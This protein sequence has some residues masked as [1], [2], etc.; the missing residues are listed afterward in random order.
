MKFDTVRIEGSIFTEDILDKIA[1]GDL[2]GQ[3]PADFNIGHGVK[4]KDEIAAAWADARAQWEI[5]KRRIERLEEKDSGEKETRKFWAFPFL[6]LLGYDVQHR[7]APEIVNQREYDIPF[8]AANIDD[9]PVMIKGFRQSLDRKEDTRGDGGDTRVKMSPHGLVQ[10][11]LNLTE[12]LYALVTN[13]MALRVLRDSSRLVK[14]SFLEFDLAAMMEEEHYADFAL[15]YRLLHVTRMPARMDR[16]PESL[17]EAYHQDSLESGA[18]IREGLSEAV[19]NAIVSMGNGFLQHPDNQHLRSAVE[20]EEVKA[21]DYYLWLLRLIYRM[22]FLM[23]IE[24]RRL[25]YPKDSDSKKQDIYYNYYS[26]SHMRK[27]CESVHALQDRHHDLWIGLCHTFS[28]FESRSAGKHL[29]IQP[30]SGDLFGVDATGLLN[31]CCLENRTLLA[32]VRSLSLFKNRITGQMMKVNYGSLNVE[33]FGSVYEG[34]LEYRPVISKSNGKLAFKFWKSEER[35]TSGSHYTPDE[36]V[37]PLI[38][39][40]L[41]HVIEEKLE[42]AAQVSSALELKQA[43]ERALLSIRVCDVA[44]G[45][46]HILLNAARRIGTEL[47][48]VRT[49]E[50][51]P[52]QV[53]LREGIRDVV[54]HCIYGVD[55]NPLA[56]EL[57]KVA[58]WLEAHQPGQPLNFLDHRIKCGDAIVGLANK[59]ELQS[60]I[61]D[62]AF[63]TLEGDDKGIAAAARKKNKIEREGAQK[64]LDFKELVHDPMS[65]ITRMFEALERMPER[66]VEEIQN[67]KEAYK[68]LINRGLWVKMKSLADMKV[69]Q[70]FIPKTVD[71]VDSL[72]THGQ[73]RQYLSGMALHEV[74]PHHPRFSEAAKHRFFHWFLEFPDVFA[75]G[76]FDCILGNPPF[77]GNRKIKSHLGADYLK[78]V[79]S[80]YAPAGAIELVGYFFRRI[81]NLLKP[82]GFQALIATNTISQGA[83]RQGGLEVIEKDGGTINFAIR[84]MKWPGLAAVEVSL[85]SIF[86]GKWT[87]SFI[88]DNKK[89]KIISTYLDDTENL[90]NPFKLNQN[91]DKSFQ[92]SIVLGKG[93]VLKPHEAVE[94]IEK[95]SKNKNVIFPYLNGDDLNSRPDQS[96]S[97]WVIN[98]FNWTEDKA[99][100]EYLDCYE[101]IKKLVKPER[102][103]KNEKGEYVLRKPLPQRWWQYGDKRPKLYESIN[104]LARVLAISEVSKYCKFIFV[105]KDIVYMHTLKLISIDSFATQYILNSSI[106]EYWAWKYSSTMGGVGLRY[107]PSSAFETFPFPQGL[108]AEMEAGL[109]RLGEEYHE[110]RRKLMLKMKLGL[111][112]TYN[113]FHNPRLQ[114]I[115]NEELS[116]KEIEKKDGKESA[117]LWRHL[118]KTEETC[119]FN[120]AVTDILHLRKLHK[121]MDETVLKA[122]GWTDIQLAHDFY[123]V[124]YLPEN[125]RTRYTIS[126]DARKDILQRLLL[127]N[128]KLHRQETEAGLTL[129]AEKKTKES[130]AEEDEEFTLKP[131]PTQGTLF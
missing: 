47:A 106:N 113:Q 22:L 80:Y 11:Y 107:T 10:E 81:F 93:F 13:G 38:K 101:I 31:Q 79:T 91:V 8:R 37:Q 25:I 84:S 86:R 35:S 45:S 116:A 129:K 120:E 124:D 63:K 83:A 64:V 115:D 56:V 53:P 19:E 118:K 5:F 62:E 46:G 55:K 18:R 128:H 72:V 88:L 122:Y 67:K 36:L 43:R 60:G 49:G 33:E 50:E 26:I 100:N 89:V 131:E 74:Q 54:N 65:N 97:R 125:D 12:H 123:E 9:F 92:G 102:Q 103:R 70:F 1:G 28:L 34:L 112:K 110:F 130:E 39:H 6:D 3:T 24:E 59:E 127:L 42:K 40:S 23:V 95:N 117:N 108:S 71:N 66:T 30:L 109:E 104:S 114:T 105:P 2:K 44:C 69:A 27:R 87:H 4:V 98:F 99:K 85:V 57:C 20:Q 73:F 52:Q 16:G 68:E 75:D 119:S 121:Q 17:I 96:P 7:S 48:R 58:L 82:N 76:G 32:A 77:L 29:D 51:Q 21:E 94:L 78:W 111:T 41:D 15:L 14:L 126:P 90:G 61:P